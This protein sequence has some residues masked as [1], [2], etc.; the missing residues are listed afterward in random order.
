MKRFSRISVHPFAAA[1]LFLLF[2]ASP[3]S[4]TFAVLSSVILHE[5][6]HTVMAGFF[7]KKPLSVRIMPT[8]ISILLPPASSYTQELLI[9]AAGPLM[10]LLYALLCGFLPY[11]V[12]GTVRGV[13]LLLAALNLIPI[14]PLDGGKML[15]AL[16]SPF[17]GTE[18][19]T[20]IS[21]F[22]SLLLLAALWILSLYIFFYSGVNFTLLLFCAYLFSYLVLKKF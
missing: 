9:A 12:G 4:Y 13:S 11:G 18:I 20:R 8:G 22:F 3:P 16:I 5:A 6:G 2:F 7:A 15:S 14:A 1:G 21:E 19:S 17:F 10:N